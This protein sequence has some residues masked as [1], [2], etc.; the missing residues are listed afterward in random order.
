[1]A[2]ETW[3][4]IRCMQ[5][6]EGYLASRADERPRLSAEWLLCH[7]TGLSR[8]ELYTNHDRPLSR[9]ELAAM[10]EGVVRRAK[11]EPLQYIVG[12]TDFRT[13]N[14]LCEPGV[15]IPRP[16]TEMLVEL[17]LEQLDRTVLADAAPARRE[18]A[19]L[20]WN[21]EVERA[22]QEELARQEAESGAPEDGGAASD[23]SG[24]DPD[25]AA[26]FDG[27]SQDAATT[28][29][30]DGAPSPEDAAVAPRVAR[31][32]EVG[33]GTGCISLSLVKER[34]GRLVAVATDIDPHAVDLACRNR[35]HAG[36]PAE[37]AMFRAGDLVSPVL[38]DEAGTFDVLV[39]NPPYIPTP[40]MAALPRVVA[41]FEPALALDGGADGLDV[42]R[43]L[44][45]AA[46][47][48]LV[49]GG[50]FACELHEDA[51]EAAAAICEQAGMV[52]V[53]VQRDLA[54]RTRFV[55][56]RMPDAAAADVPTAAHRAPSDVAPDDAAGWV[57][58]A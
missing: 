20:P 15:L 50:L 2:D 25:E 10:H 35:A 41:A 13:I 23:G 31:V 40:V 11:G 26:G 16:E 9:D 8:I 52:D 29:V 28:S 33:C 5:W 48:M 22:R 58:E 32:L 24:G 45:D 43:R 54:G 38:P 37:A 56:A 53:N 6:T 44:V 36:V 21:D 4:I 3:T 42:F 46:P 12:N 19:E 7:A 34:A 39:S 1:M 17:V 47:A 14:V 55:F 51:L 27:A 49:P 57:E 30:G 18:R